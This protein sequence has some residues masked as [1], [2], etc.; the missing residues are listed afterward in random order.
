MVFKLRPTE[1]GIGFIKACDV[2]ADFKTQFEGKQSK[3]YN[4]HNIL[5]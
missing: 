2:E 3:E 4:L 1:S 5:N